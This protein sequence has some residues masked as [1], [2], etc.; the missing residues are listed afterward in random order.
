MKVNLHNRS[1]RALVLNLPYQICGELS[2]CHRQM[3]GKVVEMSDGSKQVAPHNARLSTSIT[4][5]GGHSLKGLP[6]GVLMAPEVKSAIAR[7][8]LKS[9]VVKDEPVTEKKDEPSLEVEV[10]KDEKTLP[11][12]KKNRGG[13]S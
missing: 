4:I 3:R 2:F 1:R 12:P 11:A 5:L 13:K 6:H 10:I 8:A 9:E 7:G